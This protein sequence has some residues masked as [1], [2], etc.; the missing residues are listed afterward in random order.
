M[1]RSA[2]LSKRM[3]PWYY[4]M[5]H[6]GYNYRL[7]DIQAALGISQLRKLNRF[8]NRRREIAAAYDRAF[9]DLPH[10]VIPVEPQGYL[11]AYHLYPL[12][13]D[14]KKIGLSRAALM[15]ELLKLGVGTQVHYIPIY[16]QPYYKRLGYS[17]RCPEAQRYY[18]QTI[19]IPIYPRMTDQQVTR[20]VSSLRAILALGK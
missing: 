15:G 17:C 19:S 9:K 3:G 10:V 7:T 1:V 6:L 20:V 2:A 11:G 14:F 8:V 12:R 16:T 18:E 13:I 4:A 5:E